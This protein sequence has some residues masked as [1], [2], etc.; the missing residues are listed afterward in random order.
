SHQARGIGHGILLG[1]LIGMGFHIFNQ[2]AGHLGVVYSLNPGFVAML[3]TA[4]TL[5]IALAFLRRIH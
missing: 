4:T 2:A 1:S 3:P 5:F